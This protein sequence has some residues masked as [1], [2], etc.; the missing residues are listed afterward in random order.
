M[1]ICSITNIVSTGDIHTSK[2]ADIHQQKQHDCT[3]TK[4]SK[5]APLIL[6]IMFL[7]QGIVAGQV[8][9]LFLVAR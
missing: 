3:S 5:C 4:R 9:E 2:L 8:V 7:L 6:V 1:L